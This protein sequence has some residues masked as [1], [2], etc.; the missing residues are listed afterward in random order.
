MHEILLVRWQGQDLNSLSIVGISS[1]VKSVSSMLS[2]VKL[3]EKSR[4]ADISLER[5]CYNFLLMTSGSCCYYIIGKTLS[6]ISLFCSILLLTNYKYCLLIFF[7]SKYTCMLCKKQST[8]WKK[9][10]FAFD[11]FSQW[12][13]LLCNKDEWSFVQTVDRF[14]KMCNYF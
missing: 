3:Q 11:F 1:P 12:L 4:Q 7:L 9:W 8:K 6:F 14:N 13:T 2:C 5:F 10:L